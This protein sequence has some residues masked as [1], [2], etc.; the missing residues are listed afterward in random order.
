MFKCHA[1]GGTVARSETVS[2]VFMIDARRVLV[3]GIPAEVCTR[4]GETIFSRD[5]TERVRRLVHESSAPIRTEPLEV[6][7][8]M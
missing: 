5:T 6:F 3:E 7:A 2:E 1:C 4:C 8:L